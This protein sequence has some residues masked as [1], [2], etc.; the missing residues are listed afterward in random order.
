MRDTPLIVAA[1][2]PPMPSSPRRKRSRSRAP[3]PDRRRALELLAGCGRARLHHRADGRA[4]PRRA[5][6]RDRR[7]RDRRQASDGSRAGADHRRGAAGAG[8]GAAMSPKLIDEARRQSRRENAGT[9]R[10]YWCHKGSRRARHRGNGW[11]CCEC[12]VKAGHQPAEWHPEC[13]AA[14]AALER[15]KR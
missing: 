13:M 8:K 3:K 4:C 2:D 5:R 9:H 7:A 10:Y 15:A 6:D 1:P 14:A 11:L 12:H